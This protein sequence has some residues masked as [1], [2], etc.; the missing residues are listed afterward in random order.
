MPSSIEKNG[1]TG[2]MMGGSTKP[3]TAMVNEVAPVELTRKQKYAGRP[4]IV[5]GYWKIRGL[6]QPIRYLLEY[7]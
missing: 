4:K 1:R 3:H 5:L 7:I 6:A 2:A